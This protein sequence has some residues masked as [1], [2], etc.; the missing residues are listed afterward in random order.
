MSP[1]RWSWPGLRELVPASALAV[2]SLLA[3]LGF[4][5][6]PARALEHLREAYT[7]DYTPVPS[8]SAPQLTIGMRDD[9]GALPS[10]VNIYRENVLFRSGLAVAAGAPATLALASADTG[11]HFQVR[12]TLPEGNLAISPWVWVTS[13]QLSFILIDAAPW[14]TVTVTGDQGASSA[15]QT[16][17]T[18]GLLPGT[19]RIHFENPTLG[20]ASTVDQTLTVPAAANTLR[21]TMPGFDPGAAIDSLVR[22][23]AAA[24]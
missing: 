3:A 5:A 4:G 2:L 18:A 11:A 14:A 15:Q 19:Y 6:L 10:Q 22:P 12:A 9:A 24:Y 1:M 21:V 20:A 8:A 13:D 7:L 17:F 23:R 16:P